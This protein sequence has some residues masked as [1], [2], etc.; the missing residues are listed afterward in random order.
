M[1]N[2]GNDSLR[3][4]KRGFA[5]LNLGWGGRK[6]VH[7]N[8]ILAYLA[9][10]ICPTVTFYLFDL[11]THNPFTSM[12][13]KTQLLNIVF[14]ELTGVLLFG[15]F[16]YLRLA[17]MVQSVIF[18]VT[19]LTNYYVFSF[20]DTPIRPW[21]LFSV[22]TAARV[23]G[24][25]SY[26]LEL[27]AALVLIGFFMLLFLESR[28]RLEAPSR[29]RFRTL[30]VCLPV[31]FLWQ[32]TELIQNDEFVS[33]FG[34]YDKLFTPAVMNKR[35]GNVVAFLMELE[36]LDVEK[37]ET[38]S[39]REMEQAF[40]KGYSEKTV[41]ALADPD[42]INRPNIIVIMDEAFSD[43]AVLGGF[44]VNQDYMPFMHSLQKGA[45]NTITG[46]LD[47]S[48]LGGNTAN[49]EFEFL[50]GHS[51]AFLPQGSVAYQQY[52]LNETPSIASYL[53]S[54][55][56]STVAM[57]PYYA[58]GWDRERVY[59]L[60]GFDTFLSLDDFVGAKKVRGY[61]SDEACFDRIE[62]IYEQKESGEPLFLF[63]VTM[64][65][66][67][68][69]EEAF[70]NFKPDV[71]V[72]GTFS[73]ALN[74]YLSLLK[75]T[76]SALEDLIGYFESAEEDTVIVFFGDHQPASYV[77][78]PVLRLN[79]VDI[80]TLTE[81]DNLLKY[82]VP[83]L[84]WSNFDMVALREEDTSASFLGAD[85]LTSCGLPLPSYQNSL[86]KIKERYPVVSGMQARDLE[87]RYYGPDELPEKLEEWRSLQ[88][89]MLFD[90][91]RNN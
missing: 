18:M 56:Y 81:E 50:T 66:H 86:M 23:A 51:M 90:Y 54:L 84:I 26:E 85:V 58:D 12:N 45:E 37:P 27:E 74:S 87:G 42:S 67:G 36:Y 6:T 46:Y 7:K 57:H 33:R 77:T 65:N 30:M 71:I 31:F 43:P 69:Y 5:G 39:A 17:L 62:R 34:L 88:Y 73:K 47:V 1:D 82:K 44:Q 24:D 15:L 75:L 91:E 16:K 2:R 13:V 70:H 89:Y 10:V 32:Y 48:V 76:D 14:Y 68:G 41:Q 40:E 52:V 20:R 64:Q 78:N 35:D 63:N 3:F 9:L 28:I 38:Y 8:K 83:Y 4:G 55:G 49:T 79:G 60:L 53:K 11:Y 19:G 72:E 22:S 80:D 61:V 29:K 21:D 59:P 25:F